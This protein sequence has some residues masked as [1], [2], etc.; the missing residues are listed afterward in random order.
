MIRHAIDFLL[1]VGLAY[2][3]EYAARVVGI[4]DGDTLT[5]L[6]AGKTPAK[7]R[8]AGID[9]PESGQDFGAR[10]KQAASSIAFGKT[11]LVIEHDRDRY[12]RTLAEIILPD[13]RSMNR[14]MVGQGMAWWYR[15]YAANDTIL[16]GLESEARRTKRGLW[17]DADPVPPW[18]WRKPAGAPTETGVVGN[19][20]SRLVHRP[21]CPGAMK[22]GLANRM[23]FA[24]TADAA[25]AGYQRAGD[26]RAI[27]P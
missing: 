15:K 11:V 9:A 23:E 24:D 19:R 12:G 4:S 8:L 21:N 17:I 26:R 16:A 27:A 22:I 14:E 20:R 1:L 10:A 18:A 13:G 2:A 6:T 25:A 3:V 5:I 7:K